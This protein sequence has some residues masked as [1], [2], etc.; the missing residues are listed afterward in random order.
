MEKNLMTKEKV[1]GQAH[2]HGHPFRQIYTWQK[3]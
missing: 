2:I 3:S 1:E